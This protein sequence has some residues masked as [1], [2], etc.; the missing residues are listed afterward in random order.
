M[1][2]FKPAI[3]SCKYFNLVILTS[4]NKGTPQ[5]LTPSRTKGQMET[6]DY[7]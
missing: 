2:Y 4:K 6:H 7:A 1:L 5:N 3:L